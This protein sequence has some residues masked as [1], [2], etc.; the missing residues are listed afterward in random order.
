MAICSFDTCV[1]HSSAT[2]QAVVDHEALTNIE[3][4]R[5]GCGLQHVHQLVDV[6]AGNGDVVCD[7]PQGVARLDDVDLDLVD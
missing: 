2:H 6:L 3:I 7:T 5:P 1:I 4:G